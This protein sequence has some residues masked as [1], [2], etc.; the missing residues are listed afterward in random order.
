MTVAE[1]QSHQG[2]YLSKVRLKVE[3]ENARVFIRSLKAR[4]ATVYRFSWNRC[5]K[6]SW[7]DSKI[8]SPEVQPFFCI[9]GFTADSKC[10]MVLRWRKVKIIFYTHAKQIQSCCV[11]LLI[12]GSVSFPRMVGHPWLL[13]NEIRDP[14][15]HSHSSCHWKQLPLVGF[16]QLVTTP[17]SILFWNPELVHSLEPN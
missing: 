13:G 16:A 14:L 9:W 15:S 4:N 3:P 17:F 6:I 7:A 12:N 2:I 11:N 8:S 5:C 1:K 10:C